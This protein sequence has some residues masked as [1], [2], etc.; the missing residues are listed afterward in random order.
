MEIKI[1]N[2][3]EELAISQK[4]V[5][6]YA[7]LSAARRHQIC[8]IELIIPVSFTVT[9]LS[10]ELDTLR[11]NICNSCKKKLVSTSVSLPTHAISGPSNSAKKKP[12]STGVTLPTNSASALPSL[13]R[14]VFQGRHPSTDNPLPRGPS[15]SPVLP[16][17]NKTSSKSLPSTPCE[18]SPSK[19]TPS[20]DE[21]ATVS[22]EPKAELPELSIEYHPKAKRVFEFNLEKVTTYR[23]PLSCVSM[24][25]DGNRVA[26]GFNDGTTYLNDLKSGAKIWLVSDHFTQ[27][28]E[29]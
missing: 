29:I 28:F 23:V 18:P 1:Q 20:P 13:W 5:N 27:I 24:S 26:I 12:V 19:S 25:P 14:R 11:N 2:L 17:N 9:T 4:K 7:H 16:L 8:R 22:S 3:E 6:Q 10:E 15:N 21:G